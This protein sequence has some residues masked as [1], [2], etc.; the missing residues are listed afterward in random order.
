MGH[1]GRQ[2]VVLKVVRSPGDEWRAG[3]VL[4]AFGGRG[5]VPVIEHAEGAV[6]ME[7]LVPGTSLASGVADD[8]L[9]TAIIAE[10]I[11]R[12]SP[13]P[14][15]DSVPPAAF[16]AGSFERYLAGSVEGV[17]EPLVRQA[18][19]TYMAL[20]ASQ[21]PTRLLHGDLHH[22]NVLLDRRRGWVAIDAM[23]VVGELEYELGA[24]LRNPVRR[25]ECFLAPETI[26]RRVRRLSSTLG[27]DQHR[28]LAWAFAQ[29]VLAALWE[30][31]DD[32]RLT[33]GEYWLGLASSLS[34]VMGLSGNTPA[35]SPRDHPS[36]SDDF[37]RP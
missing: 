22:D 13:A 7:R 25:P 19:R 9:A 33:A 10:V 21:G 2:P 30:L 36:A 29:A 4:T 34:S 16:L 37:Y 28:I 20:C 3:E 15:P 5:V 11:Q 24:A 35:N 23:G 17:P 31:E 6:L 32:G 12:M 26:E 27:L 1:R 18:Q 8:D 14:A